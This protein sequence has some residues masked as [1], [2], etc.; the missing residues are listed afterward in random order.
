MSVVSDYRHHRI[1]VNALAVGDRWNASVRIRRTLSQDKPHVDL[2][3]CFKLTVD[4]AKR[5]GEIWTKRDLTARPLAHRRVRLEGVVAGS[6]LVFPV[7]RLAPDGLA[8]WKQVIERGYEGYVA[9]DEAS[10]Y[11]GGTT[12][13]WLKVKQKDWTVGDRWTRRISVER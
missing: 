9:K 7:R 10:A 8:A 5:A 6:E 4:H 13:R 12:R 11:E 3:T 2:V 1:E